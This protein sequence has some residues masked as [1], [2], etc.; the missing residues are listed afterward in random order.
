MRN[1]YIITFICSLSL[2][3]LSCASQPTAAPVIPLAQAHAHNDYRHDRPLHDALDHG[4]TGV[5]AD[6]FLVDGDLFVAHDRHEI[7]PERTLRS[8]YLDPLRERVRQNG[9]HVYPNGP[10]VT[11]LIDFKSEGVSTY[12]TLDRILT[13]YRDIF[14]SFGP[15]GRSDKAVLAV[16]SGNRP[17]EL[18]ASQKVRYAGYDGRLANLQSEASADLMPLISDNWNSHFSWK[19]AG[20]MPDAERRKLKEIVQTAHEKGRRVRF[21]AT[22]D[23]PSPARD[24]LWR[25]LVSAGVDMLN[26]DDLEGLQ[27]FLLANGADE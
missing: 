24:S 9:G 1:T 2:S 3:L 18:M 12:K 15:G 7:T 6:V 10:Q 26:T 23:K 20:E 19:G 8:L 21:W 17:Y 27:Q 11:L 16:I 5:E 13:E 14:T 4:F 22:P 25:E